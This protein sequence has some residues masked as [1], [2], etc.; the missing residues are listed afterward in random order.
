MVQEERALSKSSR[1]RH[2]VHPLPTQP[3]FSA[4]SH[5]P[6]PSQIRDS[7][8]AFTDKD[9]SPYWFNFHSSAISFKAPS[10]SLELGCTR[11]Q[12]VSESRSSGVFFPPKTAAQ[13]FRAHIV[14]LRVRALV[15]TGTTHSCHN[16][17]WWTWR[18]LV[19]QRDAWMSDACA[20][21]GGAL[22]QAAIEE[23]RQKAQQVGALQTSLNP[24][25]F[26]FKA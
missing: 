18:V 11:I 13:V 17:L 21:G 22:S 20:G 25:V 12:S 19:V 1:S 7:W 9:G 14:R 26:L 2:P 10:T 15:M 8:L 16:A 5:Q 3:L 23:R 4:Y 6:Y 24:T